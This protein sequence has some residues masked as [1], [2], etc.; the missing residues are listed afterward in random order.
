[1]FLIQANT[2]GLF[3]LPDLQLIVPEL[4]L[5]VCAC[6]ALVMEVVLPYRKSKSIAYFSLAGI[7][8]AAVS[9]VVQYLS[10]ATFPIDGFFGMIRIDGFALVFQSI[11]LVGAALAI[12]ISTR[13][14][15]IEGEQHG[16]YYALVL[17]ATVGMMFLAC[18]FDLITL[19][20]SLELM[21]L[22]FYVLVA[23]TK[24]EKRS[25]EAAMKY[26]LLGAFSS[27]VLL[28][29]M[30]LLYGVAGS[31]N[32]GEIGRALADIAVNTPT[33]GEASLRPMLLL[34]MIALAAGLFF[35]IA[36]V[37]F[38]MWAPDAYE[39]APTSVT[40]FLSTASKAASFALY[41]RIFMEALNSMRADWAPLLGIVAAI[42]IMVG[43]WAA[44][45]QENSKRLLAYSSISN[46]GYL[47]LGLVAGNTYGYI[48][49]VIYLLVYTFMNM[50][51]FGI[52]ISLRRRGIIGDNVD[53]L[54]GLAH[55]APGMAA[56]MMVFMLS[57]GGLPATGGFIGKW[58]LLYG[59]FDRGKAD[60]KNWYYWLAG[61][62]AINIVVSFY[63]YIR[64]IKVMYLGDRIADDKPL[65]LSPA[66]QTALV[67]S[68]VG[69]IF[70]GVYPQPLIQIVQSLVTR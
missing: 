2:T 58:Y 53:D 60:G 67:V 13:Y 21:A 30:S 42:T 63:Y 38:H 6:L 15:D 54:T 69:I 17:F 46:A 29:G 55:K 59:L 35:K 24:R 56:M 34:G 41:A 70:I 23:F 47:L 65:S 19:Y 27:G 62:A 11:F 16:E 7:A 37:P 45:T 1:M 49:L 14:L 51:A 25:N 12:A 32:L 10:R 52:I 39:G 64:F 26:F 31:T 68:L 18:G 28:Y 36:A 20:I 40:A 50:G 8:L 57:L 3:N 5:T 9:L 4:I 61:W 66:L 48:G 43:N 22:T 44:V 33:G